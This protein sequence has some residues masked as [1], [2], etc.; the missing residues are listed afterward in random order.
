MLHKISEG[1]EETIC[2]I[3]QTNMAVA[4]KLSPI[5]AL[6]EEPIQRLFHWILKS[7][8]DIDVIFWLEQDSSK[9]IKKENKLAK[10]VK[11]FWRYGQ[12]YVNFGTLKMDLAATL[13]H[14]T[15]S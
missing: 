7:N 12:L 8:K 13:D 6:T 2:G 1:L 9:K 15:L 4:S 3:F 14:V 10:Y 5:S 11:N